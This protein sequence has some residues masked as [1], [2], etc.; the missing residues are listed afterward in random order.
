MSYYTQRPAG[1]GKVLGLALQETAFAIAWGALGGALFL[2]FT[3]LWGYAV[4][5][6][7]LISIH[8]LVSMELSGD[9]S[10]LVSLE[11]KQHTA[12][13]KKITSKRTV[14][15]RVLLSVILFPIALIGYTPLLFGKPSLPE[16][17]TGIRLTATDRRL[18][19]R[20]PSIITGMIRKAT[21]RFRTLTIVPLAAA[22]TVFVLLHSAPSVISLQ[23][24][25][26]PD[27]LPEHEQE[28]LTHYLEL[29]ALH[30]EELEYHVRLASLYHRNS[31]Q[32]DLMNELAAVAQIDS[33]HAI[34][35]LAD[36]TV[37]TFETLE[38][39]PGDS[40]A[41]R[42]IPMLMEMRAETLAD[43]TAADSS[44]AAAS[45]SLEVQADS[46]E[47]VTTDE[48]PDSL[49]ADTLLTVPDTIPDTIP[50]ITPDTIPDTSPDTIP[51]TAPDTIP[52]TS[53]DTI[54]GVVPDTLPDTPPPL[55]EEN[56]DS[57]VEES[58][59]SAVEEAE[60]ETVEPDTLIQP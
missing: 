53:P 28:L 33:T 32:Q 57:T 30:P 15:F 56:P 19:P 1:N 43:S 22:A 16:L 36:S 7:V 54:P 60:E 14:Y 23:T 59:P 4:L 6:A 31:M 35:I 8:F 17:I 25:H 55:P 42:E 29:T 5:P 2:P 12:N 41:Q 50:D 44:D 11:I 26:A 20:H 9:G 52:D 47:L 3:N 13:G 37:F 48:N 38:P 45:D 10:P 18:D 39:L 58:E 27:G 51:D 40:S 24:S 21:I 46:T 34:L 49:F